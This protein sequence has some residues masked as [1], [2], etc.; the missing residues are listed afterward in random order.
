[1]A[2]DCNHY[3]QYK[4]SELMHFTTTYETVRNIINF[5]IELPVFG[6][7]RPVPENSYAVKN[8]EPAAATADAGFPPH[9]T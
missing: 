1:M 6:K 7:F 3:I 9:V 2:R 5:H 4:L 8:G